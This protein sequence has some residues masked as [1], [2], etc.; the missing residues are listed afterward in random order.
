MGTKINANSMR[1]GVSKGWKSNWYATG[2]QYVE[3]LHEDIKIHDLI[4]KSK[5]CWISRCKY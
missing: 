3:Y 2:N 5:S 1:I 4:A